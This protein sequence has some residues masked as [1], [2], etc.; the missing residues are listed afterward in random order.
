MKGRKSRFMVIVHVATLK[1]K[2]LFGY[3]AE[4]APRAG[5]HIVMLNPLQQY[6]VVQVQRIIK[7]GTRTQTPRHEMV[8]CRVRR[9]GS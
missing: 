4:T 2:A 7:E 6:E 3:E 1:D 9:V 8:H 5:E